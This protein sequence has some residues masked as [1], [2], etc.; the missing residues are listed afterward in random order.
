MNIQSARKEIDRIDDEI[1]KL[2]SERMRIGSELGKIKQAG[3]LPI[4]NSEREREILL[5]ITKESGENLQSCARILF[6]TLFE[7]SKSCQRRQSS[8]F[9]NFSEMILN[10]L[11]NTPKLFPSMAKVGC[12]GVPG[13][14]AQLAADRLFQ[15]ADITYFNDFNAVFQAVEKGLCQYGILP[16]ENSTSGTIDQVYD[17]MLD[18]KFHI[19]R[20]C[21][22]QVRH[23]LLLPPGAE[24]ADIKE[25]I[26]H[27]QGLKQCAGFLKSLGNVKRTA[28]SSTAMAAKIVSESGRKDIAAIASCE[29]AGIY[30]LHIAAENIQ[31]RDSNY[32]RFIC[33]S[34]QPEIYPGASKISI[35]GVLPHKPGALYRLLA[36]FAVLGVNLTKLESRPQR[37]ENF[38]YMFYFDFEAS[39]ADPQVRQLLAELLADNGK[40]TFLGNYSE[41]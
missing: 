6:S 9:G 18:H 22:L 24:I 34:R 10:S 1:L 4:E 8:E 12:C 31:D 26:S 35:M 39:L 7:L 37:N 5:K 40:F 38:E 2:F 11:N 21:R 25:V 15:L 3:N 17:L 19:V 41:I 27:E 36:R 14:Y 20:S 23:A 16:I 32:T 33:I 13:A 30:S 29:C 28:A